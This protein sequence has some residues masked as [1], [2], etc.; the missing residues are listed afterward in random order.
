MWLCATTENYGQGCDQSSVQARKIASKALASLT[1][2]LPSKQ[3]VDGSN[4]SGAFTKTTPSKGEGLAAA[5][6]HSNHLKGDQC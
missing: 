1:E 5:D 4:P 3:S 2:R 6:P